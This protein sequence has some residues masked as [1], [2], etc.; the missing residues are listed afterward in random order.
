M[1]GKKDEEQELTYRCL[2]ELRE[3]E[4]ERET[5]GGEGAGNKW[6]RVIW[7]VLTRI[8]ITA[9][10][11]VYICDNRFQV[12]KVKFFRLVLN[13]NFLILKIFLF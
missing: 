9:E 10:M 11:Y 6:C 12:L 3:L 4:S 13:F 2:R 7:R 1:K 8:W 5:G